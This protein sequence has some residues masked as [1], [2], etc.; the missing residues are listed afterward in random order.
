M[1]RGR[2][3][4]RRRG[5]AKGYRIGSRGLERPEVI[6]LT[7]G[8]IYAMGASSS[9]TLIDVISVTDDRIRYRRHGSYGDTS[10]KVIERWI[11]EDLISQG[12]RTFAQCYGV[13]PHRWINMTEGER[14]EQLKGRI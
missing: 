12:E 10:P 13:S 7:P 5:R 14:R 1:K 4:G 2:I 6:S 9:P 3:H 8:R 11:G